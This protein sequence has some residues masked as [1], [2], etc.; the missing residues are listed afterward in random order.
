MAGGRDISTPLWTRTGGLSIAASAV[1]AVIYLNQP[2][3]D[4]I[5]RLI[6]VGCLLANAAVAFLTGLYLQPRVRELFDLLETD[7]TGTEARARIFGDWRGVAFGL[8]FGLTIAFVGTRFSTD[9]PA[10]PWAFALLTAVNVIIGFALYAIVR[11]WI[12]IHRAMAAKPFRILAL[13]RPDLTVFML[14]NGMITF[15]AAGISCLAVLS[16]RFSPLELGTIAPVF[17]V[18]SVLIVVAS[19]CVPLFQLGNRLHMEKRREMMRIETMVVALTDTLDGRNDAEKQAELK[20]LLAFRDAIAAVKTFPPNGEF[21]FSAT[22]TAVV[23]SFIP[24]LLERFIPG[25]FGG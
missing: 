10:L 7:T 13:S 9:G 1:L 2:F 22:V 19:Y 12:L 17:S 18:F 6:F 3:D 21:S 11:Y 24:V 23:V 4:D 16:L 8:L 20:A 5:E 15:G 25:V 14:I